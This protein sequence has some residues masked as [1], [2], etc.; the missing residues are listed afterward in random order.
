MVLGLLS[1]IRCELQTWCKAPD[2]VRACPRISFH[3]DAALAARPRDPADAEGTLTVLA[4]PRVHVPT[5]PRA[6]ARGT[7]PLAATL[8]ARILDV[9][10]ATA[11]MLLTTEGSFKKELKKLP[12]PDLLSKASSVQKVVLCL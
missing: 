3:G 2:F 4:C 8:F 9:C 5:C 10:K 1:S 11:H 6:H 12:D 7:S